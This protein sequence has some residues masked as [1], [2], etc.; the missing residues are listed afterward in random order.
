[1]RPCLEARRRRAILLIVEADDLRERA[2]ESRR[3]G[4]QVLGR[5]ARKDVRCRER[6][7]HVESVARRRSRCNGRRRAALFIMIM[8]PLPLTLPRHGCGVQCML[9]PG[10]RLMLLIILIMKT[11]LM[12]GVIILE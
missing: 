1:M 12:M 9:L 5:P 11:M 7:P 6:A 8:S 2:V 3:H 10:L 4:V